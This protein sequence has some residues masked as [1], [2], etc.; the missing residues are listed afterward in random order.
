I[1]KATSSFMRRLSQEITRSIVNFRQQK[2][3]AA[4]KRILL[5]GRSALIPGLTD[6]LSESQRVEV[7]FFQPGK[8]I[9]LGSNAN[10]EADSMEIFQASELI[11]EAAKGLVSNGV[12]VDLLPEDL[13]KEMSFKR[14]RPWFIAAALVLAAA[15]VPFYL[16]AKN[17]VEEY[18]MAERIAQQELPGRQAE[19]QQIQSLL[20][21]I[22]KAKTQVDRFDDLV[23]SK[24]NWIQFF[25]GL[26]GALFSI[27]DVWLDELKVDRMERGGEIRY[28]LN[29]DG[30]LL[31][32]Q[33]DSDQVVA[34]SEI[35]EELLS[36]RIRT[37]SEVFTSSRFISERISMR[38][39]FQAIQGGEPLLPFEFVFSVDPQRPL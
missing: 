33:K 12:G 26:Q 20:E 11:G 19:Y 13:R 30:R 8:Y 3:G 18:E 36:N 29:V 6:F 1:D 5:T 32:R 17:T 4:P 37:L 16:Q 21:Q 24:S 22:E 7:S 23:N 39:D 14:K 35:D 25:S 9:Q 31:V 10:V 28:Q 34:M 38:I 15:P 27:G 2:K